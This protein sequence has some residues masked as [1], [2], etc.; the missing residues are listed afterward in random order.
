MSY[1]LFFLLALIAELIGT[2]GGFGSSMLFVPIAGFFFDFKTVLGI[3]A[4]FHVLSNSSKLFLFRKRISLK[5]L[6][7]IGLPSVVF[8]IIGAGLSSVFQNDFIEISLGIFLVAASVF[9]L[10]KPDFTLKPT[11]RSS[12]AGGSAAGFL[13]GL[14]GTGGAIRGLSLAAFNLE[15]SAF[16]ATSAAIDFGVDLSRSVVYISNGYFKKGHLWLLPFLL[17]IA[18]LGSWLGKILLKKVEHEKFKKFVLILILLIGV[19]MFL[20]HFLPGEEI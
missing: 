12:V 18:F 15:K 11:I 10:I 1:V 7:F 4:V 20:K 2:L 14:I 17:I 6:L 5:L 8:V 9:L 3:T 19:T 16:I 13:A